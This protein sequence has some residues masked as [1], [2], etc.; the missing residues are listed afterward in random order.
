MDGPKPPVMLAPL[1]STP[2]A[3]FVQEVGPNDTLQPLDQAIEEPIK[4][5]H[6]L[7]H[8]AYPGN[9]S[10][11]RARGRKKAFDKLYASKSQQPKTKVG[12]GAHETYY[13]FE[14]LQ[15]LVNF[16]DFS[17]ELGS[18]LGSVPIAPILNGHP[19][20]VTAMTKDGHEKLWSFDIWHQQLVENANE[21]DAK[22]QQQQQQR[23]KQNGA[24]NKAQ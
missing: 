10:L 17:I 21:Y 7:L 15:H 14:F 22:Q 16:Q 3:L 12:T 5:E 20:P 18:L 8:Q 23:R 2:Q 24:T 13:T 11:Q 1:G 6:N 19:L 4:A 9:S